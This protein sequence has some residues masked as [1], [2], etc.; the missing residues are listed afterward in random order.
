MLYIC[1][2]VL[3]FHRTKFQPDPTTLEDIFIVGLKNNNKVGPKAVC[4]TDTDT[5]TD[6][7]TS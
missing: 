1:Q 5:D 4:Y 2:I 7:D 6:S 3:S